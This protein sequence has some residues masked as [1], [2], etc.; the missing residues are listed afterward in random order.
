MGKCFVCEAWSIVFCPLIMKKIVSFL[1]FCSAGFAILSTSISAQSVQ[2]YSWGSNLYGELGNNTTTQSATPVPVVMSGALAGKT[3]K[4]YAMGTRHNLVLD[5]NG[6]VYAWGQPGFGQL[7]F[8][9]NYGANVLTPTAVTTGA[10]AGKTIKAVAA[11]ELFSAALG[12]DGAIYTWGYNEFGQLGNGNSNTNGTPASI[13]GAPYGL[14]FSAISCGRSHMLALAADGTVYSWGNNTRGQLGIDSSQTKNAYPYLVSLPKTI[15]A[16]S[17][18]ADHSLALAADGTVYAWGINNFN[19]LGDGTTTDR[20]GPVAVNV[21]AGVSAMAGKTIIAISAGTYH[22]MALASD[23][24]VYTWGANYYLG[25]NL[26]YGGEYPVAVNVT[27]G[28]SALAGKTVTAISASSEASAALASDGSVYTWGS[29]NYGMLGNNSTLSGVSR[30]PVAVTTSSALYGQ[31]VVGL[32]AGSSS[33]HFLVSARP[34]ASAAMITAVTGPV[35]GNY[36]SGSYPFSVKLTYDSP[37]TVVGTPRLVL[38]F[39]AVTRYATYLSGS[40]TNQL[41]FS[42]V[43]QLA[44]SAAAI[45]LASPVDLNGGTL[46]GSNSSAA[47]LTF[48]PP[49]LSAVHVLAGAA[50]TFATDALVSTFK[51]G[52]NPVVVAKVNCYPAATFSIATGSLPPGMYLRTTTN[53][54]AASGLFVSSGLIY[55]TPNT[56]GTYS[57]TFAATNSQGTAT[58]SFSFTVE[59]A[60][61]L[62]VFTSRALNRSLNVGVVNTYL[63]TA[64]GGPAP[65]YSVASGSLPP[66]LTLTAAGVLSGT[67]TTAG[68]FAGSFAATN[69]QGAATQAFNFTVSAA[70]PL[71]QLFSWGENANGDVGNNFTS[72]AGVYLPV[73]VVM[74]GALAGKNIVSVA[75]GGKHSLALASD[76]TVYA[77]GLNQQGQL[78]D[79]I[80]YESHVPVAVNVTPGSSAL[81]GVTITAIAAGGAHSVALGSDGRVY[82]WGDNTY[83]QLGTGT[84]GGV[85]LTPVA[86]NV[87][88]LSALAGKTVIAISAGGAH[89]MALASDGTVCTWGINQSGQLGNNSTLNQA[90]PVAVNVT[91]GI[92]AL[93]GKTVTAIS[94]GADYSLTLASNGKVYAWGRNGEGQLGNP[95]VSIQS[96]L[97]VAVNTV[98]GD[99]S[100]AGKTITA[101]TSGSY[102]GMALASDGSLSAWGYNYYGQLGNNTKVPST[103]PVLVNVSSGLSSLAGKTIA[104]IAVSG[105]TSMA[106]ASDHSLSL[107]GSASAG[108]LGTNSTVDSP[109]PVSVSQAS[110]ISALYG[111]SVIAVA[112]GN[113][114]HVLVLAIPQISPAYDFTAF[115]NAHFTPAEI[116]AGLITAPNADADGDGQVNLLEFALGTDPRIA[117][118]DGPTMVK[119]GAVSV[120]RFTRPTG[121]AVGVTYVVER[122]S[123][124]SVWTPVPASVETSGVAT[125]T[126]KASFTATTPLFFMRLHV[127]QL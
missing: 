127:S 62:P 81:A 9:N 8:D 91:S 63:L 110:G 24:T 47:D 92:S 115:L 107:W 35:T 17:A 125:E 102:H 41:T 11:G 118:A 71:P 21:T 27:N 109:V 66:G 48:I 96:S 26:T 2:G 38:G 42:Y 65:T 101:I 50:P 120:F 104:S 68:T 76:G 58:Q 84:E 123:D 86:V 60:L 122:S 40:G 4:G 100:L 87:S 13:N 45:T 106:L 37:I 3:L 22:S 56:L 113:S 29:N 85:R 99:S 97:P 64:N 19:Q 5:S 94:A 15:I 49:D 14:A 72:G 119:E 83:G 52:S 28:T 79:V 116:S 74:T 7:G 23:G 73:K 10:I 53:T 51:Q 43:S 39:G 34:A 54:L 6:A 46:T 36:V 57:G 12:M 117:S 33:R 30:V 88:S 93:N 90:L 82:T 77:W 112:S 20:R 18:G 105:A 59:P 67:P 121:G 69:S 25:N 31:T 124:L 1:A 75:V 108:E 103:L 95:S 78:G 55:G 126:M 32:A 44:D 80:S 98:A 70:I 114:A 61:S 111:Q 16:I 89:T